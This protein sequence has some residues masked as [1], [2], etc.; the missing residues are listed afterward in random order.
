MEKHHS[1]SSAKRVI[2]GN[3]D[4]FDLSSL[5][6]GKGIP[7]SSDRPAPKPDPM[8]DKPSREDISRCITI[9]AS[10]YL[11]RD[12]KTDPGDLRLPSRPWMGRNPN[13]VK[14]FE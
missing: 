2:P 8:P 9:W 1:R 11:D 3:D 12:S 7:G 14:R 4:P 10:L 5:M 13:G 6:L